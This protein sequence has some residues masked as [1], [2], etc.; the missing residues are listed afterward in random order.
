MS[1]FS[2]RIKGVKQIN[3]KQL[4]NYL[5]VQERIDHPKCDEFERTHLT[6]K[7]DKR[8]TPPYIDGDYEEEMEDDIEV[9]DEPEFEKVIYDPFDEEIDQY[10]Q[11][12]Y[13]H[14]LFI[15]DILERYKR[16]IV[17]RWL[18]NSWHAAI[19]CLRILP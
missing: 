8:I 3:K 9:S 6:L 16:Q 10:Y 13:T 5:L 2:G 4:F 12:F 7:I 1:C 15:P 19:G 14:S 18:A 17:D 11:T